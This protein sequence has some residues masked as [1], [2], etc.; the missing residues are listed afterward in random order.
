MTGNYENWLTHIYGSHLFALRTTLL[1]HLSLDWPAYA[2]RLL[3]S[4]LVAR[5]L[6]VVL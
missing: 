2:D 6:A 1:S 4:N 3:L 5:L